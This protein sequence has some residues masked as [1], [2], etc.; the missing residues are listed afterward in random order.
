M[1][2][3]KPGFTVLSQTLNA[4][5]CTKMSYKADFQK[6]ETSDPI[7]SK[8]T[9]H[10]WTNITQENIKKIVY[11]S[12]ECTSGGERHRDR[13]RQTERERAGVY[14]RGFLTH[15]VLPPS[16]LRTGI[17][18]IVHRRELTNKLTQQWKKPHEDIVRHAHHHHYSES[19]NKAREH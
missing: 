10:K 5:C 1:D 15:P 3:W 16:V 2:H 6:K 8:I 14:V 17:S 18:V 12:C 13:E 7:S 9:I 4:L 11:S 19:A